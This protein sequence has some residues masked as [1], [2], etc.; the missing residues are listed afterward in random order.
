[1]RWISRFQLVSSVRIVGGECCPSPK[2]HPEVSGGCSMPRRRTSYRLWDAGQ[3][4][5][6][7][8]ISIT[9]TMTV[10]EIAAVKAP[11]NTAKP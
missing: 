2:L 1:M 8:L 3:I 4:A 6:H 7:G 5:R 10:D 11:G 9:T